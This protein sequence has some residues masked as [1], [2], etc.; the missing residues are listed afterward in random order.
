MILT[1]AQQWLH[2]EDDLNEQSLKISLSCHK[3]P[4]KGTVLKIPDDSHEDN[5]GGKEEEGLNISSRA[6]G[7]E[8][9][10]ASKSRQAVSSSSCPEPI[11]ANI[12]LTRPSSSAW[13]EKVSSSARSWSR[14]TS[15]W[16]TSW[17]SVSLSMFNKEARTS[18][19][20]KRICLPSC[21][22]RPERKE[23]QA[24]TAAPFSVWSVSLFSGKLC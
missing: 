10:R 24:S 15:A 22:V 19:L 18:G 13:Q 21:S 9:R 17:S 8:E 23:D 12:R 6:S 5:K 16:Q 4:W 11:L 2:A 20:P 1:Q 14:S 7:C 3:H